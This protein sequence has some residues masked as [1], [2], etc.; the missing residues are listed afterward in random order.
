[1]GTPQDVSGNSNVNPYKVPI[2]NNSH[3]YLIVPA[4]NVHTCASEVQHIEK[5]AHKNNLA[6][7]K[8]KSSEM[9]IIKPHSNRQIQVSHTV[10]PGFSRVHNSLWQHSE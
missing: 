8:K 1:M 7:N 6:L 5:W 3:T 10:I 4:N 9:V 2:P